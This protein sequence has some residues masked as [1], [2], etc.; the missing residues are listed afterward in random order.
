MQMKI[1]KNKGRWAMG[2][3][4]MTKIVAWKLYWVWFFFKQ[5]VKWVLLKVDKEQIKEKKCASFTIIFLIPKEG[6]YKESTK[7]V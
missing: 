2:Y 5:K 4:T 7:E 1:K 3:V 6:N